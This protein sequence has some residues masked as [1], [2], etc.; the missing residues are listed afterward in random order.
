MSAVTDSADPT[1]VTAAP[2]S[3]AVRATMPVPQATSSTR[4]PGATPAAEHSVGAHWAKKAGTN[5]DS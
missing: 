3:A 2:W 1:P 4:R 5:A